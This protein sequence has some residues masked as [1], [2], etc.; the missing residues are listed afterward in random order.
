MELGSW[1]L[2]SGP[3][4]LGLLPLVVYIVLGMIMTKNMIVPLVIATA[5]GCIMS[6]NGAVGFGADFNAALGGLMGQIGVICLLGAGLGAVMNETGV[7]TTLCRWLINALHVKTRKQALV[8][9]SVVVFILS[10]VLGSGTVSCAINIA[11][12]MPIAAV[13]GIAPITMSVLQIM[14]GFAGMTLSPFSATNIAAMEITGLSFP[15]FVL[16]AALPYVIVTLV[17]GIVL[18]FICDKRYP[19]GSNGEVY[20]MIAEDKEKEITKESKNATIA[21]IVVFVASVAY[22]IAFRGGLA[23]T[24]FYMALLTVVISLVGRKKIND[25]VVTFFKSA[26]GMLQLFFTLILLQVMLDT[27][28][29]MGGFDALGNLLSG[30]VSGGSGGKIA[31]AVIATIFGVFGVNG[32]AASQMLVINGVFEPMLATTGIS[33]GLWTF[34]LIMGSLPSNFLYPGATQWGIMGMCQCGDIKRIMRFCWITV[35]ITMIFAV[36]YAVIAGNIIG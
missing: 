36:L 35:G 22:T 12:L 11:F 10:L 16:N 19:Q 25:T 28:T 15:Q 21:F 9:M 7:T 5:V 33:M 26:A 1:A 18:T 27:I 3:S 31:L 29:A 32:A 4:L 13:F 30:A 8:L 20:Q 6:G 17:C 2:V 23:F 24:Y 34:V 14:V